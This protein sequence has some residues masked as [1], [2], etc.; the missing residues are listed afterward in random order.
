MNALTAS[1][2][3]L[4]RAPVQAAVRQYSATTNSA[5]NAITG[6]TTKRLV[7]A[8]AVS[9]AVGIDVTYAY[10]YFKNK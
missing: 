8:S 7:G 4:L 2:V 6:H 3:R 5:T 1:S 9:F 10:F